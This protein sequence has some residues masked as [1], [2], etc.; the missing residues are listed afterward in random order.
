MKLLNAHVCPSLSHECNRYCNLAITQVFKPCTE[1]GIKNKI[2][3]AFR[4]IFLFL[5]MLSSH[6]K[7]FVCELCNLLPM[8]LLPHAS[9]ST[10][11]FVSSDFYGQCLRAS[12][13]STVIMQYFV[14][15]Y[16]IILAI[17]AI[18][19]TSQLHINQLQL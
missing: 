11:L 8:H 7:C 16:Y 6:I 12:N 15:C 4:H 3:I 5:K 17:L 13:R 19:L 18:Y 14:I 2:C 10:F 9:C 1:N